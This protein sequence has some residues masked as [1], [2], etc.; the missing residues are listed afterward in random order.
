MQAQFDQV[1]ISLLKIATDQ[2]ALSQK[3]QLI[4]SS[5]VSVSVY[6]PQRF[7]TALG[8]SPFPRSSLFM[9]IANRLSVPLASIFDVKVFR[10]NY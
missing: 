7:V 1:A 4:A 6:V 2:Y 3:S 5:G 8:S 10:F 9:A